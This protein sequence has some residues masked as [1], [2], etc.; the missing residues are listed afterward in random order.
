MSRVKDIDILIRKYEERI[1]GLQEMAEVEEDAH[2]GTAAT[3]TPET[4]G[5]ELCLCVDALRMYR[6]KLVEDEKA[7]LDKSAEGRTLCDSTGTYAGAGSTPVG[8]RN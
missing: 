8:D 5:Y 4:I 1:Q 2:Y 6:D 7:S 3:A